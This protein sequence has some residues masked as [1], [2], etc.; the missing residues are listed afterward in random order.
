MPAGGALP[1]LPP[2]LA[3]QQHR[4]VSK[5]RKSS[6]SAPGALPKLP[7]DRGGGGLRVLG[8]KAGEEIRHAGTN[9]WFKSAA[10]AQPMQ[11]TIGATHMGLSNRQHHPNGSAEH[12]SK[13]SPLPSL[14]ATMPPSA[15]QGSGGDVGD[16][17]C[18]TAIAL[19][20]DGSKDMTETES[21]GR[22][23]PKPLTKIGQV[24]DG[25]IYSASPLSPVS[26]LSLDSLGPTLR[27]LEE[28]KLR[29]AKVLIA[30]TKKAAA[31]GTIRDS[32]FGVSAAE[33][34]C[35]RDSGGY[36]GMYSGAHGNLHHNPA[37][38]SDNV[39]HAQ[40]ATNRFVV[41][42]QTD[43]DGNITQLEAPWSL[44]DNAAC[45]PL[46][47]CGD[48]AET[49]GT[50]STQATS[51]G[52]NGAHDANEHQGNTESTRNP[53]GSYDSYDSKHDTHGK[54]GHHAHNDNAHS[55][56]GH[57]GQH[58][59]KG[60]RRAS[61]NETHVDETVDEELDDVAIDQFIDELFAAYATTKDNRGNPLMNN[62]AM[63]KF[64]NDFCFGKSLTNTIVKADMT[65]ANEI[66]RQI[67]MHFRFDL[68][69]V[70]A[71]RGLC[72]KA[73]SVCMD[74]V[75]TRGTSRNIARGWFDKYSGNAQLM[76]QGQ[77]MAT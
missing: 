49:Q 75:M 56:H 41:D 70:E 57:G 40:R 47:R 71:K 73:F 14:A 5:Q 30:L 27:K 33:I 45:L 36:D 55:S 8:D 28:D 69:K 77:S 3:N 37:S 24:I 72:V 21:H 18:A 61:S 12:T 52:G 60:S 2:A 31:I 15:S 22:W 53:D 51:E 38:G 42:Q 32:L 16:R 13:H 10:D 58:A 48:G 20:S 68:S 29:S 43:V 67:D 76:R 19:E 1:G 64:F 17:L 26:K 25:G 4:P 6:I 7:A 46:T 54:K 39:G 66:E 62:P 50:V 11:T 59:A 74:Q 44:T 65:Y 9:H 34:D 23:R 35:T 63:R